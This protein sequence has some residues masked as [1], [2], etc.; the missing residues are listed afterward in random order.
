MNLP[1][2]C[3]GFITAALNRLDAHL[4]YLSEEKTFLV[5]FFKQLTVNEK[6]QCRKKMLRYKP[7]SSLIAL[8]K[9]GKM[10]TPE[11]KKFT[12]IKKPIWTKFVSDFRKN[13]NSTN[14][15]GRVE[16][17][18][19]ENDSNYNFLKKTLSKITIN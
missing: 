15:A 2:F 9:L 19:W 14:F 17:L 13:G 6:D 11:V 5:F 4:W 7:K 16:A 1:P 3:D 8:Q 12:T 18:Q 10:V